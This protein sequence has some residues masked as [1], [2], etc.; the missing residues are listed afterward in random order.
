MV[1]VTISLPS[2]LTAPAAAMEV[3]CEA[4]TIGQALEW[5]AERQPAL[6]ARIFYGRRLL[7]TV[8]LNGRP[9]APSAALRTELAAGDRLELVPPVAGG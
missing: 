6:G 1:P 2:T 9:V 5:L 4:A 3:A 8:L 7:V